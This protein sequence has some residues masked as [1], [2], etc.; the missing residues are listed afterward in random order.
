MNP[1]TVRAGDEPG[2]PLGHWSD[3]GNIHATGVIS[4]GGGFDLEGSS[5][6]AGAGG[7]VL[8]GEAASTIVLS[9]KRIGDAAP[10]WYMVADG[11]MN[12]GDGTGAADV[13]LY[14]YAAGGLATDAAALKLTAGTLLLGAAGDTAVQYVRADVVGTPDDFEFLTAGK[15]L[16]IKEGSNA[17][18]GTAVLVAGTLVVSTTAVTAN[19]RIFLTCQVPG[20]TPGFLRVS[21]RVAATSFTILSSSGTDTSTVAW[22]IVEPSA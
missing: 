1:F 13:N 16:N 18:M 22:L 6:L 20:G 15:G 12:W 19:S 3:D 7:P 10:R 11:G 4:A 14:R 5:L 8:V 17:R 9:T 2:T 21:A